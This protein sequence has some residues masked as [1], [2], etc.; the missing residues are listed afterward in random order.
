MS[1]PA[2]PPA[3]WKKLLASFLIW[4][5]AMLAVGKLLDR[6]AREGLSGDEPAGLGLGLLHGALMPMAFPS[7]LLGSDVAIYAARNTGRS[8]RLGYSLGVNLCGLGF[9]GY[10]FWWY[11]QVL[12]R[13]RKTLDLTLP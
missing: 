4:T 9:F 10:S 7:L 13:S 8:Y 6:T 2:S 11:G 3:S 12:R 5:L 1:S